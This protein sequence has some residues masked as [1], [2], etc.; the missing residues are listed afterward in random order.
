MPKSYFMSHLLRFRNSV[1]NQFSFAF[2]KCNGGMQ[3]DKHLLE[4]SLDFL[5]DH[6]I[7]TDK[8]ILYIFSTQTKGKMRQSKKSKYDY[9]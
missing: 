6:V 9:T 4:T 8:Q 3:N 1:C 2:Y 5:S 7:L